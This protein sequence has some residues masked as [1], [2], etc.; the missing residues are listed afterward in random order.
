MKKVFLITF[1]AFFMTGMAS[2]Q[3]P[4]QKGKVFV[5]A[6]TSYM[7]I[8]IEEGLPFYLNANGGY[9]LVDN[10]ALLV[11]TSF[12]SFSGK[13]SYSNYMYELNTGPRYYFARSGKGSF[14]V[15][16]LLGL[17]K[18]QKNDATFSLSLG[19][20]YAIFLNDKVA[21]EPMTTYMIPLDSNY[22]NSFIIGVG[23]SVFF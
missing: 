13:G 2:A 10:F 4:I 23:I 18:Y 11:G 15:N 21:L 20:G 9:F 8:N 5:N 7:R 12:I 1:A 14:F 22:D 3:L 17:S 6:N 19:A 16:S